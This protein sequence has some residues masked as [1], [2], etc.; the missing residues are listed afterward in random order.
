MKLK[1][2]LAAGIAAVALMAGAAT[3][4]GRQSR[5]DH[6]PFGWRCRTRHRR[7]RRVPAG[8]ENGRRCRGP[9]VE[10]IVEDDQRKPDIA[11][12]LADKMIPVRSGRCPDRHHLVEP[13]H[14][15]SFPPPWRRGK[16]YLSPNAGPSALAGAGCDKNYFNVCLAERQPA[17]GRRELTRIQ[18]VTRIPS[19]WRRT[20]LRARM[21]S[22]ATSASMKGLRRERSIPSLVRPTTPPRSRR[23]AIPARILCSSSCPAAWG[24]A[25]MKQYA[26]SGVDIPL[27]G[28]AFSFDQ[29]ILQ[30]VGDAALGVKN[31]SQWNKDIDNPMNR[32][33][34][35]AY[36][37]EYGRLPSLYSSQ[38]FDT[39]N[40]LLSAMKVADVADQ[41]AFRAA[42]EV[43]AF[44]SVRGDFKFAPEPSPDSGH[45]CP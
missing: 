13:R 4:E 37:E 16:F 39:A 19:C 14:G 45:L 28:P 29:N 26:E 31:T 17:R 5:H 3:A 33:F 30:A 11:V 24:I 36:E 32:A 41:D 34:V 25:F 40:L 10:L 21:P 9:G 7:A 43:A 18:R 8:A 12:Q 20:I 6:D 38:G 2:Q 44:P 22:P 15:P 42:L 1:A 23:S 27:V 35:A